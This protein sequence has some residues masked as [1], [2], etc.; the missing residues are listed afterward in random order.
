MDNPEVTISDARAAL[1]AAHGLAPSGQRRGVE[2][3][4][5]VFHRLQCVQSDPIDVA[6]RNADLT[7]QSRVMDYRQHYLHNLLYEQRRLFEFF[8][9]MLSVV[10][11][12]TYPIFKPRMAEFERKRAA[13]FLRKYAKETRIVLIAAESGPVSS[14]E[15]ANM[16]TMKGAWG[17]QANVSSVILSR[18]WCSGKVMIH[19][20]E[21]GVKYYTLPDAV[22]P[23]D[24]LSAESPARAEATKA[25]AKLII[26]ASRLVSAARSPEQWYYVGKT[27]AVREILAALEREGQVFSLKLRGHD[28]KLFAPSEDREL[29]ERPPAAPDEDYVRFLAPLDPLIWN[30][31][32]FQRVY[33]MDYTW[34]VYKRPEERK[35][36]YY[37]LPV[38][39]NGAAVGL[40]DPFFRKNDRVLEVRNFHMLRRDID[41]ERFISALNAALQRFCA[42]LGAEK[43]ETRQR[44]VG[45]W[46]LSERRG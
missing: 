17:H 10:P 23:K 16:G 26:S 20:R 32:L 4:L 5:E 38:M 3:T 37:C 2:G 44:R 22:I 41:R 7:L 24:L 40:I 19:H 13:A 18:L 28:E 21:G 9:K 11:I 45:K 39:F 31:Q 46:I 34:E 6:G 8:C 30:R 35:F 27:D 25:K 1:A 33:G 15:F 12:E 29:W 14:R 43:I 36:G 42:Y